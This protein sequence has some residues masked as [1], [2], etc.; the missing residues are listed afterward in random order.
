MLISKLFGVRSAFLLSEKGLKEIFHMVQP[1]GVVLKVVPPPLTS[2]STTW[3][4]VRINL[5][6]PPQ[7]CQ[8]FWKWGPAICVLSNPPSDSDAYWSLST[9]TMAFS[10]QSPLKTI[11][12]GGCC[13]QTLSSAWPASA[14]MLRL[15]WAIK[16]RIHSCSLLHR[17]FLAWQNERRCL[18]IYP[19]STPDQPVTDLHQV[20]KPGPLEGQTALLC[21]PR[22][23]GQGENSPQTA[24]LGTPSPSLS[25]YPQSLQV[26]PKSVHP[27]PFL[28]F[29]F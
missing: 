24:R 25:C 7:L 1:R 28:T 26:F 5:W 14:S 8:K 12:S 21:E 6:A 29:C 10:E 18:G 15:L 16:V 27:N 22:V 11:C 4:L 9:I 2:I 17:P 23:S 19:P 13:A 20:L 3:E